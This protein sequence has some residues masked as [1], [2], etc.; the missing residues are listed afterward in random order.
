M[1]RLF[2][3]TLAIAALSL[4]AAWM[5]AHPGRVTLTWLDWRIDTSV[6]FLLLL[7]ALTMAAGTAAV[8]FLR[9]LIRSPSRWRR[10]RREKHYRL[11]LSAVTQSLAALA[12]GNI[13]GARAFLEQAKHHLEDAP[14]TLLL[15]AQMAK[16]EG[17]ETETHRLLEAMRGHRETRLLAAKGLSEY[18]DR[19]DDAALALPH[20]E[21]AHA[22]NPRDPDALRALVGLHARLGQWQQA[23]QILR[24][25]MLRLPR[26]ERRRLQALIYCAHAEKMQASGNIP[27]AL[28]FARQAVRA[29]P[30]FIPAA[31][32]AARLAFQERQPKPALAI[33]ARAWKQAPHAQLAECLFSGMDARENPAA[34]LKAARRIV[35]TR[36]DHEESRLLIARA[37]LLARTWPEARESLKQAIALHEGVRA[38][39]WMAELETAQY[40]DSEA[41]TRWT[42]RASAAGERETWVCEECAH[43]DERW[44][45]HCPRCHAFGTLRWKRRGL[46]YAA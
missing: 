39:Q 24:R 41:A 46:R 2:I 23:Q 42:L 12:A 19:H 27:A 9:G 35:R 14:V 33:L 44:T 26:D 11:G 34:M 4:L 40:G 1:L 10:G 17:N 22:L 43:T 20:A 38:C 6:A 3:F 5:S 32:L 31:A 30:G 7:A 18:H 37:A 36:P 21:Q 45:A 15:S 29:Q 8:L 25:S 28:S 16:L 13:P